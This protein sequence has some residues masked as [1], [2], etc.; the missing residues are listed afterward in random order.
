[1]GLDSEWCGIIKCI[2]LHVTTRIKTWDF[3][4]KQR[5]HVHSFH[6]SYRCSGPDTI[7]IVLV[8]PLAYAPKAKVVVLI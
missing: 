5:S 4:K 8:L 3:I 6:I 2:Q 1:M 7:C